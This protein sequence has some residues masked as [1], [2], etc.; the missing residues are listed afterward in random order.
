MISSSTPIYQ[1]LPCSRI[2]R[3]REIHL[4]QEFR[5]FRFTHYRNLPSTVKTLILISVTR[6]PRLIAPADPAEIRAPLAFSA[7]P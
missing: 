4:H 7:T 1:S 6:P 3:G 5:F 2:E